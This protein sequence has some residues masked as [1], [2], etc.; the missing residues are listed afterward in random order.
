ML[1]DI[2]SWWA[3]LSTLEAVFWCTAAPAS[4]L[5]VILVI[6]TLIGGDV[7]GDISD[8]DA[9]IEGDAGIGFQFFTVKNLTGFFTIFGWIGLW[10]LGKGMGTGLSIVIAV[11]CGGLMMT[12]MATIFYLMNR[13]Q[14]SGTLN[15]R[16]A[17]GRHGEVY[18]PIPGTRDGFG[19]VQ[20]QVQGSLR[21]L[22]AF[23]DGSDT[24]KQGTVVKVLDVVDNHILL[25][26]RANR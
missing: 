20:I 11:L 16:N 17:I 7:D 23:T 19:K 6:T 8:V 13:L 25:V 5:L 21:E 1:L 2:Q 14:E 4:A 24:L 9:E 22:D 15:L 26:E 10:C 18:L 3:G 12:L